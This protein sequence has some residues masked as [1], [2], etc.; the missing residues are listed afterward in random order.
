MAQIRHTA[1]LIS[2]GKNLKRIRNE[3]GISQDEIALNSTNI[4]T[5]QVGRIERG[6]INTGLSTIYELALSLNIDVSELFIFKD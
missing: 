1:F 6:E 5:N 4:S 3:K 2:F